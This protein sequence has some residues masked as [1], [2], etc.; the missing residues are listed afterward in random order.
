MKKYIDPARMT[1]FK[2]GDFARVARESGQAQ[3]VAGKER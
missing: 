3:A 1:I 2:A